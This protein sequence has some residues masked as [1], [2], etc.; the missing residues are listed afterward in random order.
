MKT[1]KLTTTNAKLDYLIEKVNVLADDMKY[2]KTEIDGLTVMTKHLMH[3]A[4]SLKEH[5]ALEA[6]VS[7]LE[8]S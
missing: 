3:N 7:M 2:V 1:K 4:V 5:K 8:Q 6:R